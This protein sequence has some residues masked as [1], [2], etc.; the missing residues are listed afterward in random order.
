MSNRHERR[1]AA[2]TAT[3]RKERSKMKTATLDQHFEQT[4]RRVRA[5]F[6]RAGGID[7]GFECVTD[8]ESFHVPAHWPD[9]TAKGAACA[10]LRDSFRRRGVNRYLFA[11]ECWVGKTPG[12]RP[13][14]DPDR[15]ESVQVIAVERNGLRRYAFADITRNGGIAT[16]GPWQLTATATSRKAGCW[17]CWRRAIQTGQSRRSRRQWGECR[18]PIFKN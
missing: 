13:A 2:A 18:T 9:R 12:L 16:L 4:L 3:H 5:E 14:D 10:G 1:K 11:S 15:G 7:P 17:S 8:A 6:E